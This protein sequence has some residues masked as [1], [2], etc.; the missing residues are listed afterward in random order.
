MR[1]LIAGAFLALSLQGQQVVSLQTSGDAAI[2]TIRVK[3]TNF[4]TISGAPYSAK[5]ITTGVQTRPDGNRVDEN[6]TVLFYRDSAGRNRTERPVSIPG[7]P[8]EIMIMDPI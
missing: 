3:P 1:I 2:V 4:V 8:V 5:R 7:S 6:R